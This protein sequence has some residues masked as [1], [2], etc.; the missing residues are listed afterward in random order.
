VHSTAHAKTPPLL[1]LLLPCFGYSCDKILN[2]GG[3]D[4]HERNKVAIKK[5]AQDQTK[6]R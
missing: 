2:L 5:A 6:Q 1:L 4:T 3:S